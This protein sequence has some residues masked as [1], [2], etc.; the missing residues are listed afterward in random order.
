VEFS[1]NASDVGPVAARNLVRLSP[2]VANLS[3]AT[4]GRT[5][6]ITGDFARDTLYSIAV[7]PAEVR[8]DRGRPLDL[9]G[10]SEVFV[11]FRRE[12]EFVRLSASHGFVERFGPQAIPIEGRGQERVDLR[13]HRVPPSTG[14]S[15]R[16]PTGPS[17]WTRSSV[18]PAPARLRRHTP[19]RGAR[20][21]RTS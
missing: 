11:H 8:D 14:R 15:G 21:L 12:P 3:F 5:L 17:W 7:A 10:R 19:T 13:I 16:S 9:R 1:A 20:S 6:A 18:R 4:E 2:A